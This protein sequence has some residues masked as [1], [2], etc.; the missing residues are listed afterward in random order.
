MRRFHCE[1]HEHGHAHEPLPGAVD[2][3][4]SMFRIEREHRDVDLLHDRAQERRGFDRAEALFVQ[5]FGQRI[6]FD[7]R[8]AERIIGIGGAAANGEVVF[9]EGRKQIGQCLQRHDDAGPDRG[10]EA[11]Q[12][13]EDEDGQRPLDLRG[14]RLGPQDPQ[15]REGAGNA[16]AEGERKNLLVEP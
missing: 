7:E 11:E 3:T 9:A 6:D 1:Q 8:R 16:G 15:R 13:A 10:G 2:D 4:E 12:G 5:R 14:V